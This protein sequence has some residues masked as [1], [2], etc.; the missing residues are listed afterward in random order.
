MSEGPRPFRSPPLFFAAE[1]ST[2]PRRPPPRLRPPP[3]VRCCSIDAPSPERPI[4]P[5]W[6][7]SS[8][9]RSP[10]LPL[11]FIASFS[12]SLS[13]S[14]SF[15]LSRTRSTHSTV[16]VS[17]LA[18]L[19]FFA[20]SLF[21][22]LDLG[23]MGGPRYNEGFHQQRGRIQNPAR[24]RERA[25]AWAGVSVASSTNGQKKVWRVE[26]G[27]KHAQDRRVEERQCTT[28]SEQS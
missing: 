16:V 13:L 11:P 1:S 9:T 2:S 22:R 6:P 10:P 7:A 21:P 19:A 5:I 23:H 14:L 12:L 3:G 15:S 28:P 8:G 25:R 17:S 27:G 4:A 24:Q 18:S 20:L 26:S